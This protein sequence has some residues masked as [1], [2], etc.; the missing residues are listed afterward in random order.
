MMNGR[1]CRKAPRKNFFNL[2]HLGLFQP[3][4]GVREHVTLVGDIAQLEEV[5]DNEGTF[6]DPVTKCGDGDYGIK[7]Q[8]LK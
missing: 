3:G 6:L 2:L 4:V 7:V 5:L 8:T 1:R